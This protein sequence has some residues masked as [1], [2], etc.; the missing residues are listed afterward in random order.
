MKNFIKLQAVSALFIVLAAPVTIFAKDDHLPNMFSSKNSHGKDATYSTAGFIDLN[1]PFF[2]SLGSNG[3]SCGSC[4]IPSQGWTITPQGV[5]KLFNDTKGLDPLFRLVDGAN[6]PDAPVSTLKE[7]RKAYSMLL[8]KGNIRVGIGIP[9]TAEFELVEA[10]DPYGFA[11]ADQLSLFRRPMPTTNFKFLSAVMWDGRET[12]LMPGSTDCISGT[13]TCFSPVSFD[14]STQSNHA[15][16]GHAEA[17]RELT[18]AEREA[19]VA[20]ESGLF[21]AQIHDNKAG[22]LTAEKADGGPKKLKK[23]DYHFGINDTLVGDYQTHQPFNPNAMSLYDSWNKFNKNKS[24]NSTENARAAIARGQ[25]LFNTKPIQIA[26]VKG[27]NDDLSVSVLPGTCTT[28]HNTPNSGNHS[29]P[30]PLDIG[31]SDESRRTPDMPLYTLKNKT[32][33]EIIKTTDPGRALI[34]GKWKDIGRFKGP[35]LRSVASRP[36]YFHDGSAADLPAVVE[37]YNNRFSIGLTEGE[38]DDLVAFLAAL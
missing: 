15:T 8:E 36:P 33:N 9:D 24:S 7:R 32:T 21:T 11:S 20:F 27:I 16:L 14:L 25:A 2:K 18:G 34:T 1:N 17:L 26:G 13:T 19:I 38:K 31:I 22:D 30:M 37:F 28:C 5:Q 4:H 23:Q 10:D 6:A 3:R 29:T 12:T 35:I